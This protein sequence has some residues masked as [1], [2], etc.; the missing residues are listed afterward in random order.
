MNDFKKLHDGVKLPH[1]PNASAA[2]Y[3]NFLR[4]TSAAPGRQ[5]LMPCGVRF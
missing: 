3:A 1:L 5:A 2:G 4:P